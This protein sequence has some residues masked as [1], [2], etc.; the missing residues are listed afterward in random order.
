MGNLEL[1]WVAL[2]SKSTGE[3]EAHC[4]RRG[5]GGGAFIGDELAATPAPT[6]CSPTSHTTRHRAGAD[7]PCVE[8]I[9]ERYCAFAEGVGPSTIDLMQDAEYGWPRLLV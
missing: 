3:K 1:G 9:R 5:R 4:E 7:A 2:R 8:S 6:R